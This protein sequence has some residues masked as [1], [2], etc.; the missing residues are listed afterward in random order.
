MY[1]YGPPHMAEQ[2]QD[3]QLEH[4][5]SSYVRI[6]DVALKTCRGLWTIGRSGER[7]SGISVQEAR[8]DDDDDFSYGHCFRRFFK[9]EI[10]LFIQWAFFFWGSSS[11]SSDKKSVSPGCGI[12]WRSRS[13][14]EGY[15]LAARLKRLMLQNCFIRNCRKKQISCKVLGNI[16]GLLTWLLNPFFEIAPKSLYCLYVD[17]FRSHEV[18]WVVDDKMLVA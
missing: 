15:N 5:S 13:E 1:S 18:F 14:K 4:T 17:F 9:N 12:M 2:K 16:V 10:I 8:H 7:G 11:S 6:R 3:D